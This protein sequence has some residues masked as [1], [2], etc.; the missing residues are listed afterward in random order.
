MAF[1]LGL[2]ASAQT[3]D[4]HLFK[5]SKNLDIFNTLYQ[6]L[7]LFYVDS[8]D[9]DKVVRMGID[10]MLEGLDPYTQYYP[11]EDEEELK[12]MTTGKYGG[13]GSVIRQR[14]DSTIMIYEPYEGMPA[15]ELGLQA[16]DIITS[17]DGKTITKTMVTQDVS[18]MLRGEPG[19]TFVLR[20]MR[21]GEKKER[22]IKVTRRSI[23][24]S[25]I[26]YYNIYD[27]GVGFIAF[28]SFT[29]GSAKEFRRAVINLKERG[30]KSLVIDLRGNGGGS[31]NEAVD[32]VNLFVPKDVTIVENRGKVEGASMKYVTKYDPLDTEMPLVVL[33]NGNSASASEILSGSLQDLD[34]AVIIGAKTFGKGLVQSVR[35]LP[36]NS[37]FKLTT[38]KYYIPSGRCIQA[39]DY[40]E[41]RDAAEDGKSKAQDKSKAIA[42]S[43]ANIFHTAGGRIVK[44]GGG[45]MPDIVM[46]HDTL[47]NL[48]FYLSNVED[49]LVDWGTKYMQAHQ[50]VAKDGT[51]KHNLPAVSE[52]ALTD[53][54]FEDLKRM[55][56]ERNFKYDRIS[57]KRLEELKKT[58][59]FE[60]YYESAKAEFDA[61]EKKLEHNLE[62]DFDNF[63]K[64]IMKL[65]LNEIVRRYAFQA[66][67]V[68]L[69]LKDD[70][71]FDRARQL[72]AAPDDYQQ[73]LKAVS[74]TDA[75]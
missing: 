72:L 30:A 13:I 62:G 29:E 51:V 66:G 61:L 6:Q 32:I 2:S 11:E 10:A 20:I 70:E 60:G 37:S 14:K 4:D 57:V 8:L 39:I 12:M 40:K 49:V 22:E 36:Y 42:D 35:E 31:L 74:G 63:K 44:G 71:D 1:V 18:D 3:Q 7:D 19:T 34:R 55:A 5:V 26:P 54:D 15:A 21:P 46:K 9:A 24:V 59:Q 64:D 52:F 23:K 43:L 33:V 69:G 25:P 45:I 53:E 73:I 41:R 47:P 48:L 27:G 56:V 28:N 65:Q 58:A 75:Q 17:I 68:E 16:G 67:Q 38:A 50:T